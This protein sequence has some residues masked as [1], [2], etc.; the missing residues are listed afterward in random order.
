MKSGV[1]EKDT[2]NP[3]YFHRKR[4]IKVPL[5]PITMLLYTELGYNDLS[6]NHFQIALFC[7]DFNL[8]III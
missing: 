7:T 2:P 4:G 1:G 3:L 8:K 6:I 5:A